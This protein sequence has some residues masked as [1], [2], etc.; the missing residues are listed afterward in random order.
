MPVA[1]CDTVCSPAGW[2]SE[3]KI[4]ILYEGLSNIRPDDAY[5]DAITRP[6]VRKVRLWTWPKLSLVTLLSFWWHTHPFND[7]LSVT[8]VC[9]YQKGK[10]SLD[11]TEASDSEWQWHHL[12]R[13]QVCISLQT[14]NHASTPPHSFFYS[15][16]ALPATQPT[17]SKHWRHVDMELKSHA[18]L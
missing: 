13:M 8:R 16:D 5:N 10:I 3:K 6:V 12:G 15:P 11:F 17:A 14:D 9:R 1:V 7:P 18:H 2:D 4:A